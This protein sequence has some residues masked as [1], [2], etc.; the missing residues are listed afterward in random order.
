MGSTPGAPLLRA[1]VLELADG[2]A[3][4]EEDEAGLTRELERLGF[5][6]PA[7]AAAIVARL[8]RGGPHV[9]LPM[10]TRRV[11]AELAETLLPRAGASPDPEGALRA[12][13]G[14]ARRMGTYQTFYRTLLDQP[15]MVEAL[16]VV[17]GASPWVA[18]EITR[19]P[20]LMDAFTDPEFVR[21]PRSVEAL[22]DEARRRRDAARGGNARRNALRRFKKRELLRIAARDLLLQ[23]APREITEELAHLADVCLC[24]GLEIAQETLFPERAAPLGSFAVIGLGRLGGE[25]LHYSSD[26]DLL[27]LYDP[28]RETGYRRQSRGRRQGS[29]VPAARRTNVRQPEGAVP[30]LQHSH[31]EALATELSSVMQEVMEEGRLYEIDLR[32]RPEGKSGLMLV[33]LDGARQYYGP[34]GRSQTWEKQSLIKARFVAGDAGLAEEFLALVQPEVYPA[35]PPP[36]R[37]AEVRAMKRRIETERLGTT[38]AGARAERG[39]RH[40][41]LGPGGL[42]DV[43]FLVQYLQLRHGGRH[44]ELRVRNTGA[45]LAALA[46]EAILPAA[47]ADTLADHYAFLTR[48]R[49]RLYLRSAGVA[50]DVL[51]TDPLEQRRLARTM[52]LP[53]GDA[54]QAEYG[55]RAAEVRALFTQYLRE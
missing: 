44:P 18:E 27:Y 43:E 11:F 41:K 35:D 32:L 53:D 9:S 6:E 34:G 4:R 49:Q 21:Q 22:L 40:V 17:A 7:A 5:L 39:R 42:S 23:T 16:C 26:L 13:E 45:A 37:G 15:D 48:L 31:Y 10:A 30:S 28:L 1:L 51:P 14:L 2:S 46:A 20:E 3:G 33:H 38:E 47:D 19:R 52:D 24:V 8:A 50:T 29:R 12:L 54:L 25:E 55:R 36:E